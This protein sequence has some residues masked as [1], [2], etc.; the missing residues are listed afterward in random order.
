MPYKREGSDKWWIR[1][2]GVRKSAGTT[3]YKEAE[4]LEQHLNGQ[5]WRDKHLG[6]KP[7][8]EWAALCNKWIKER[9]NKASF[10]FDRT[11]IKWW[12]PHFRDMKDIREIT[13]DKVDEIVMANRPVTIEPSSA[14]NTA[15]KYV[16]VLSGMLNAACAEWDWIE[17][18]PK[19]RRYPT[20]DGR[21]RYLTVEEWRTLEKE[22]PQHLRWA[23]TFA[24]ATG[25]RAGKVFALEWSQID[26]KERRMTFKGTANKL[27]NTIPLNDTAMSVLQEIRDE[28]VRHMTRVFFW[29][30]PKEGGQGE[31]ELVPLDDYGSAWHK[32]MQRAGFGKFEGKQWVG[33]GMTFHGLRHTFATWLGERGVPEGVIDRLGGW[34]GSRATRERYTHLN[35]EH[36]RQF[37]AVIDHALAGRDVRFLIASETHAGGHNSGTG[38]FG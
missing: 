32:A 27:G 19:L 37:A 26:L 24:L 33:D 12:H 21:E 31:K 20:L 16:G 18:A 30:R 17:R 38:F 25:L 23:A 29:W 5:L 4:K 1:V 28:K 22:L 13:R 34:S 8:R 2:G 3:D 15:N 10:W 7:A 9:G 36:L 14:N 11:A 35:V 6:V